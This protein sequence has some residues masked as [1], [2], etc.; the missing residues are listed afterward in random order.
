MGRDIAP[1]A[2]SSRFQPQL[3][4]YLQSREVVRGPGGDGGLH[5]QHVVV[6]KEVPQLLLVL[7]YHLNHPG[8]RR[9]AWAS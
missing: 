3:G 9:V 6:P 5:V 4:R 1:P 2:S 7:I 8:K